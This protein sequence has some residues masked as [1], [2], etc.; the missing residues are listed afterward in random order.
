M[1]KRR[2]ENLW[3]RR[4]LRATTNRTKKEKKREGFF[5]PPPSHPLPFTSLPLL[6]PDTSS[7]L[8]LSIIRH[9]QI[10][11]DTPVRNFYRSTPFCFGI[12]SFFFFFFYRR[13]RYT[14]RLQF[15]YLFTDSR[16]QMKK[17]FDYLIVSFLF[18][19]FLFFC[20]LIFFNPS[21]SLTTSPTV[22]NF[23]VW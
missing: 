14:N 20:F 17:L 6:F 21:N 11:H 15:Y 19:S 5:Q 12:F 3:L 8:S 9:L 13:D 10:R 22:I 1:Y 2:L 23:V 16:G 7:D 4:V 18:L